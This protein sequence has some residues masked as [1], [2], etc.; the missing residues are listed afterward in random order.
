MSKPIVRKCHK[1]SSWLIEFSYRDAHG[2][3]RRF[4]RS[5]GKRAT[6]EQAQRTARALY[7]EY[8]CDP[9]RSTQTFRR[10]QTAKELVLFRDYHPVYWARH[11]EP[12]CTP[13]TKR[14]Y[15]QVFRLHLLPTFGDEP[16]QAITREM[17]ERFIARQ[18]QRGRSPKTINNQVSV[19]K[20]LLRLAEGEGLVSSNP[21]T[22]V[23]PLKPN[24]REMATF[25]E[26]QLWAYLTHQ[27]TEGTY[28]AMLALMARS[29]I[30]LGEAC[31]L[32][33]CDVEFVDGGGT[34]LHVRHA[35]SR[36]ELSTTKGKRERTVPVS[37]KAGQL[38]REHR[39]AVE[40]EDLDFVFAQRNGA[41]LNR[42][43]I[44][45]AHARGCRA[46]G[47]TIRI[48]DL[49]HTYGT[50]MALRGV[51]MPTL[52]KLMGHTEINTTM[53]YLHTDLTSMEKAALVLE[54]A[55]EQQPGE[56]A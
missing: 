46:A 34:R 5:A 28:G 25:T 38:L 15:E 49:R 1:S 2:V 37:P 9:V 24:Q 43:H 17:I 31:A 4:R 42:N 36:D 48:H 16:L 47:R 35:F 23:K 56:A 27:A 30:R 39:L 14:V 22:A 11:V 13:A 52:Q 54:Q 3:P 21:A 40:G 53:R 19:L 6:K 44:K 41:H 50:I 8:E 12:R 45:H 7:R 55:L 51:P 29:G 26:A 18:K 20:S 10:R 33:W 32:R